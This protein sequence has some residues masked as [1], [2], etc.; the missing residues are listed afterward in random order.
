MDFVII[1]S[2]H[3]L[4]IYLFIYL[5]TDESVARQSRDALRTI[6]GLLI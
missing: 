6:K 1:I 5:Y 3:M 4:F 2:L